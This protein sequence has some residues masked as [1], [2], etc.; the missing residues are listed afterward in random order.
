MADL[1]EMVSKYESQGYALDYVEA[2]VCQDN[3]LRCIADGSLNRNVT[4]KGGVV[5]RS[6]T[7][8]IGRA[9]QDIDLDFIRYSLDDDAI[10]LVLHRLHG[11]DDGNAV[12]L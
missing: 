3:I 1:N 9:T 10:S 7:G 8:N 2:R 4:I 11:R 5:M 12:L 6:I